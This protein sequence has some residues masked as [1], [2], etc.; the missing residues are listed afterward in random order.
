PRIIR[1]SMTLVGAIL[2]ILSTAIGFTAF[3]IQVQVPAQLLEMMQVFITSKTMFLLVLNVFLLIA[4][5]VM[6]I[7]GAIFVVVPLIAPIGKHF[8]VDPY[9][10]AI[11]FLVNLEIAYL[12]PPLGLNLIISS[13]RFGVPVTNVYRSVLPF[14]AVLTVTLLVTTYVPWLS[15]YL[16]SLS[17]QKDLT[18]EEMGEAPSPGGEGAFVPDEDGT[19]LDDL[20]S[21]NLDDLDSPTPAEGAG[22]GEPE[23]AAEPAQAVPA[24]PE[25]EPPAPSRSGTK[26]RR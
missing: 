18:R 22:A 1:E 5:M 2:A 17:K 3:L 14:I 7:F 10:L 13:F 12:A 25:R 8:G 24:E 11:M 19:T 4:G 21:I 6:E 23:S 16:P 26:Q 20:D 9:H 15:T